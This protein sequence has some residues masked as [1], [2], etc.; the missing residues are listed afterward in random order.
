LRNWKTCCQR[1]R[2]TLAR[3]LEREGVT[4]ETVSCRGAIFAHYERRERLDQ[5]YELERKG[6]KHLS[7]NIAR[8]GR[9]EL[10]ERLVSV[11]ERLPGDGVILLVD[12]AF[13]YPI[14]RYIPPV[15]KV[16]DVAEATVAT[17]LGEYVVTTP[18]ERALA[19]LW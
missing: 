3:T 9:R 1:L 18:I 11:V 19:D 17:E 12:T 15:A 14:E 6:A 2:E 8:H 4:V 7:A 5:L 13:V 10:E 16:D